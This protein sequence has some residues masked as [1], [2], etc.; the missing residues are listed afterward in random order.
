MTTA[1]A[2]RI[3]RFT[4]AAAASV[5]LM[6]GVVLG[7]AQSPNGALAI[8]PNATALEGLPQVRID[9]TKDGAT[10]HE[11]DRT[12]AVRDR[13]T[14]EIV[15]GRLYWAGGEDRPL[16]VTSANEFVYLSSSEPGKYVRVR[17]LNGRLTY[18]EHVDMPLGSVTFWGELRMVLG[19]R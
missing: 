16:I 2:S 15:D 8:P 3:A 19:K 9:V 6:I 13:L 4:A 12:E 7:Q 18:I 1:H 5:G 14:I 17:R 10:R 11:L